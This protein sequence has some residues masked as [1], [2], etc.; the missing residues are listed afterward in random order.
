MGKT[1]QKGN[2]VMRKITELKEKQE[3][4]LGILLYLDEVCR[5]HHLIYFAADGTLLGLIRHQ[6]FIPWDDDVDVWMPRADY[7]KLE[8]IV[9][10]E[11]DTPYRV[12]NFHNTKGFTLAY[13]KLVHTGT[14]LVEH[15]A[16]AV[17]TGLFV[18]I[19][20]FDGLP[21]KDTPE[22]DRHWKK[23]LFLESQRMNAFRT[24]RQTLKGNKGSFAK[25]CKWAIRKCYGKER[26]LREM[27]KECRKSRAEDSK[28]VACQCGGYRKSDAIPKTA[29]EEIVRLPF[30]GHLINAPAG[31]ETYLH[32]LYGDYH[33][34][35]PE[36]QR[37]PEH[38][39][40]AYWR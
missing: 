40:D 26:I 23:L 9:N 22:Y 6:G 28:W 3:I 29:I 20:P 8:Q 34:L 14:S 16:G 38:V 17:D 25:W 15:V 33:Q 35:P 10:S 12:M 21:E 37:H 32:T 1:K 5:K 18:D 4:A 7:E 39:G 30:E 24:Y 11:T 19:F 27:E 2:A 31:Y 36:D 13:G